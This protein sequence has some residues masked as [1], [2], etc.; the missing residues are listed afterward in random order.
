MPSTNQLAELHVREFVSRRRHQDERTAAEC[1]GRAD[2]GCQVTNHAQDWQS[3]AIASAGPLC[4][5]DA[6]GQAEE[7][8]LELLE[9][10][11]RCE[12]PQPSASASRPLAMQQVF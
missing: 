1:A 12:L 6:V 10:A 2:C 4:L 5:L 8:W 11:P 3:R 7:S 9:Q